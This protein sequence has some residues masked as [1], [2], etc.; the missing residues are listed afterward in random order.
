MLQATKDYGFAKHGLIAL[1]AIN[2][3]IDGSQTAATKCLAFDPDAAKPNGHVMEK[4]HRDFAL[5]EYAKAL[6]AMQD[7]PLEKS[8]SR[9]VWSAL[10]ST[11]V[12]TYFEKFLSNEA[13]VL[14]QLTMG[15][16]LLE[17]IAQSWLESKKYVLE[18]SHWLSAFEPLF[19]QY[20]V[21]N[22]I[23]CLTSQPISLR[24]VV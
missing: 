21:V 5:R 3:A 17:E 14:R 8:H 2:K 22:C 16:K 4:K 6:K 7:V 20:W 18:F 13:T 24:Y 15:E 10:I 9:N 1:G 19:R 12:I 11:L 23:Q